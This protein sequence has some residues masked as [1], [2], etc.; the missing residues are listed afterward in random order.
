VL[1]RVPFRLKEPAGEASPSSDYG[2]GESPVLV[3][4]TGTLPPLPGGALSSAQPVTNAR[5]KAAATAASTMT[6]I[7]VL[8]ADTALP[9]P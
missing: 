6:M 9:G 1:N 3:S 5:I 7:R 2:Y 4:L 8:F